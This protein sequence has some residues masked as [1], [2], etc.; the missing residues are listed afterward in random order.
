MSQHATSHPENT[1]ITIQLGTALLF[2]L[3]LMFISGGLFF[4]YTFNY[5]IGPYF[6]ATRALHFY[7][8]L[9]SIP[10]LLAKYGSTTLR[11]AG[12]YLHVPR[13]KRRG[14]PSLIPRLFSPLLA[15]D[16]FILYFSGLY[17]LFHYYYFVT[18]IPPLDFKPVQVHLWAAILAVPLIAVHLGNHLI[19][20]IRTL[21]E[22]RNELAAA[23]AEQQHRGLAPDPA[24]LP[25][26]GARGRHRPRGRLPEHA[27]A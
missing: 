17:M 26:H 18:N 24:R 27:P 13:F 6:T 7:A 4:L 20:V 23:P 1:M 8:G 10:F 3:T 16:F 9:A 11:F 25:R 19:E 12:Y 21:S 14:P 15:L 5:S 22:R 2:L